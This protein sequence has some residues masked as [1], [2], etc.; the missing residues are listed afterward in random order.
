MWYHVHRSL[1]SDTQLSSVKVV[2]ECFCWTCNIS[3]IW[4]NV[5]LIGCIRYL[6]FMI[7]YE[8]L[9]V[10]HSD[11]YCILILLF[12]PIFRSWILLFKSYLQEFCSKHLS[13]YS[14]ATMTL[15]KSAVG[16]WCKS[17]IVPLLHLL[18][19]NAN[20]YTHFVH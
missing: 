15:T 7:L 14:A 3:L 19:I 4:I 9:C 20:V 17:L 6:Q 18:E 5:E 11:A 16:S 2:Y 12:L 1:C 8:V 10:Y 13:L